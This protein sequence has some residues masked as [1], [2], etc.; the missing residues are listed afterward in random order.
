MAIFIIAEELPSNSTFIH[1]ADG[2]IS[3]HAGPHILYESY[4]TSR[5]IFDGNNTVWCV[6]Q[7]NFGSYAVRA[8]SD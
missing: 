2:A 1:V 3:Y 4:S 8:G 6:D 7:R 5:M